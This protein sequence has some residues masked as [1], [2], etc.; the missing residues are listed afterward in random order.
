MISVVLTIELD[1]IVLYNQNA[2][3]AASIH[4][5]LNRPMHN[6]DEESAL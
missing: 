6:P 5:L 4:W 3:V 1:K 2:E